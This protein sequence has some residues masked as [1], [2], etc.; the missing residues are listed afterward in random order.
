[1]EHIHIVLDLDATLVHSIGQDST[2]IEVLKTDPQYSFLSDRSKIINVVDILDNSKKGKGIVTSF[3]VILRPYLKEFLNFLL[4]NVG[5]ITI[6]SAGQKRYVRSIESQIFDVN[7]EIYNKKL[8]NV[9]TFADCE[10]LDNYLVK[11][12]EK[13]GFPME[14]TLIIDDN[15][16]TFSKNPDNAIYIS[17]YT[18]NLSKEQVMYDDKTLLNIMDWMKENLPGCKDV[19]LL[20]KDNACKKIQN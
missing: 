5:K 14:T 11:D 10:P 16:S 1:M 2:S 6:Y 4:D 3:V 17:A 12:L 7:N 8:V 13:K 18:P 15:K 19:R 20:K 9:L